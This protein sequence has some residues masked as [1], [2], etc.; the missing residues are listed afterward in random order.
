MVERWFYKVGFNLFHKSW[1]IT[2][3]S[4]N[5]SENVS[6]MSSFNIPVPVSDLLNSIATFLGGHDLGGF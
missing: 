4:S 6:L 2:A 3:L 1:S 5:Q